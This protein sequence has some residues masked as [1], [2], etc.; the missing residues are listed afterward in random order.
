MLGPIT[1]DTDLGRADAQLENGTQT[2][3]GMGMGDLDGDGYADLLAGDIWDGTRD[4]YAGSAWWL[5]GPVTGVLQLDDVATGKVAATAYRENLGAELIVCDDMDGDSS[6]EWAITGLGNNSYTGAVYVYDGAPVGEVAPSDADGVFYGDATG[7]LFGE[8]LASADLDG[9]GLAELVV[10]G[11]GGSGRVGV[12]SDD[13]SGRWSLSDAEGVI[14]GD[15]DDRFGVSVAAGTDLDG[16]GL[17]DLVIGA[18]YD[19]NAGF[20]HGTVEVF[21]GPVV[22]TLQRTDAMA[23]HDGAHLQEAAGSAVML[24]PD[25]DGDGGGELVVGASDYTGALYRQGRAYLVLAPAAG[26]TSLSAAQA[27][28]EGRVLTEMAGHTL[29]YANDITGDGMR[30]LLVGALQETTSGNDAGAVYI[31]PAGGL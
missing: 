28:W 15:G 16:D 25:L 10:G 22:G 14:M 30:N 19:D 17:E 4:Q 5:P 23:R 9:D 7:A 8:A 24:V 3:V 21:G 2:G 1:A 26:S 18:P 29:A 11:S 6:P 27:A 20:D 31:L 12:F 13:P